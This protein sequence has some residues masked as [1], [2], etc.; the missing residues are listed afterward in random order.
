M[1][2]GFQKAGR[3][4]SAQF[5]ASVMGKKIPKVIVGNSTLRPRFLL[6]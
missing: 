5:R 1:M 6:G 2:N 3:G 4:I